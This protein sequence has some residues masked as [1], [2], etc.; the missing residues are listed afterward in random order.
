M[1]ET[2]KLSKLSLRGN[3]TVVDNPMIRI[4]DNYH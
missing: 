1:K 3:P 4:A 2:D